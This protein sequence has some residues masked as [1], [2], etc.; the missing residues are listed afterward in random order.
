MIKHV[1]EHE[2][3]YLKSSIEEVKKK[4]KKSEYTP[5][6]IYIIVNKKI[7]S[8]FFQAQKN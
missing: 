8:R 3:D 6:I 5:E 2:M 4:T 7:N 1:L